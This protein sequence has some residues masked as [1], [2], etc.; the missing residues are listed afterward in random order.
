[1]SD[2]SKLNLVALIILLTA[3]IFIVVEWAMFRILRR[4]GNGT[5]NGCSPPGS[6]SHTT[7][8]VLLLALSILSFP[9]IFVSLAASFAASWQLLW[10]SALLFLGSGIGGLFAT[11]LTSAR[12]AHRVATIGIAVTAALVLTIA[13]CSIF[14][15]NLR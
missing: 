12:P 1:M 13:A 11:A 7:A 2:Q 14:L 15:I 9:A 6:L 4:A 8:R 5:V 10:P 3:A